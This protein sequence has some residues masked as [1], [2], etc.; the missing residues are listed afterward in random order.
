VRFG[1]SH[2]SANAVIG[3]DARLQLDQPL[4]SGPDRSI[5]ILTISRL[6]RRIAA[7]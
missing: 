2:A 6:S 7:R 1:R 3:I 5:V 4:T